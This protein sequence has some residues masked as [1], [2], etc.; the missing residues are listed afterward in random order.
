VGWERVN[1]T[2]PGYV[3]SY[4]IDKKTG[5]LAATASIGLNN[6]DG[7][8]A[9][10]QYAAWA[11]E[12]GSFNGTSSQR[13][14]ERRMPLWIE[15]CYPELGMPTN[16]LYPATTLYPSLT[17]YPSG[18]GDTAGTKVE[19]SFW[20]FIPAGSFNKSTKAGGLSSLN[21]TAEDAIAEIA[22]RI[23]RNPRTWE[24]YHLS[25]SD[26]ADDSL[27]HEIAYLATQREVYNYCGDSSFESS[28]PSSSWA[29][30]LS[31]STTGEFIG[32]R[33]GPVSGTNPNYYQTLTIPLTAGERFTF[34]IYV[35]STS[36]ITMAAQLG[37][38][39][40]ITA[41][42]Y[43]SASGTHSGKGW[44]RIEVTHEVESSSSTRLRYT[45]SFTGTISGAY[46]DAAMLV[47]G[48]YKPCFVNN[49]NEGT[50]GICDYTDAASVSYD[51]IGIDA[52]D[53]TSWGGTAANPHPWARIESGDSVWKRL[54]Q[55][56]DAVIC[57]YL[58]I[59]SDGILKMRSNLATGDSTP[60][61]S[62][63]KIQGIGMGHFSPV[64]NKLKAQG[65]KIDKRPNV[66]QVWE[67]EAS[68]LPQDASK[69]GS[70]FHATIGAGDYLPDAADSP[71]GYEARY[72]DTYKD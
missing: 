66:E 11:P 36:A 32:S 25:R 26:P 63:S 6:L 53:V 45:I 1:I 27:F 9:S 8:F 20:G 19:Q 44:D 5:Y 16:A 22:R 72:G 21:I 48:D 31:S 43:T 29:N 51:W 14:L 7:A 41:G 13:Y 64:A 40:G 46:I 55:I 10:D 47:Y 52:D 18:N 67:A 56:G 39:V 17:L 49:I 50:A 42:A 71:D 24:D 57:R 35:Y 23:V 28:A 15:I 38:Y 30:L 70:K 61:V 37:E 58:C 60:T 65:C 68:N 2:R 33:C 12:S 62:I 3:T 69:S 59:T 4:A 54:K 34:S